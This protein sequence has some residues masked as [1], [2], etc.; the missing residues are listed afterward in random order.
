M[1]PKFYLIGHYQ[2]ISSSI[3]VLNYFFF[4][5]KKKERKKEKETKGNK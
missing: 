2:L 5:E 1:L 4:E 3:E